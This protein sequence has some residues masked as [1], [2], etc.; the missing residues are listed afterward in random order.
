M[1]PLTNLIQPF[2]TIQDTILDVGCGIMTPTTDLICKYILGIDMY[3]PYLNVVKDKHSTI[4]MDVTELHRFPD[5]SYDVVIALDV[6]EHLEIEQAIILLN[7]LKRIARKHAFIFTPK[8]FHTNEEHTK[9]VWDLGDNE[10][11][12]HRCVIT[13]PQ[14][15]EHGFERIQTASYKGMILAK[16]S[17]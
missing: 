11:Q 6:I 10:L 17:G 7:N 12:R 9:N 4:N 5:K 13:K 8:E 14:L 16:W 3:E 1:T 15:A 2:I